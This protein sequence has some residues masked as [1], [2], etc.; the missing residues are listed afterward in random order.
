MLAFL[1]FVF[2]DGFLLCRCRGWLFCW[3]EWLFFAILL[4]PNSC[5]YCLKVLFLGDADFYL[6]AINQPISALLLDGLL[7][8]VAGVLAIF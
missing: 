7:F 4:L 3:L 8:G 6:F 5:L 1:M 2:F